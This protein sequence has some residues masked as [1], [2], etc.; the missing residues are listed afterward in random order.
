[1][2]ED[3]HAEIVKEKDPLKRKTLVRL[4]NRVFLIIINFD[5]SVYER[6]T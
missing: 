6:E 4:S 3:W 5:R 1:M 2:A